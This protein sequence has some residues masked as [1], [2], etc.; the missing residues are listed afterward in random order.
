MLIS[1]SAV[2]IFSI[3]MAAL[4]LPV[5]Q[6][7]PAKDSSLKT[8]TYDIR[9]L[10]AKPANI[11]PVGNAA[12]PRWN[13]FKQTL[14]SAELG[15]AEKAARFLQNIV[16]FVEG[17]AGEPGP[18]DTANLQVVNGSRLIVRASAERHAEIAALIAAL[19]RLSDLAITVQTKLYEIDDASY[20]KLKNAKPVRSEE[21]RVGKEY[22]SR[23]SP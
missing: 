23:S 6:A 11:A 16:A 1:R 15:E 4:S 13:N 17:V 7:Q 19:R 18:F 22:T 5:A 9:D 21:R 2:I 8:V 12:A 3:C 20:T 14:R 10:L